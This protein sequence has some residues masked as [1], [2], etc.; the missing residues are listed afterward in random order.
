M[1]PLQF[2]FT[3]VLTVVGS[4]WFGTWLSNRTSKGDL[5]KAIEDLKARILKN[6]ATQEEREAKQSR[7]RIL[8]AADEIRNGM[9]HSQEFFDDVLEDIDNYKKYTKMHEDTFI[10]G[11]AQAAIELIEK[12]YRTCLEKN[13]FL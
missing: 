6:E 12:T 13:N 4:S 7:R 1:E 3:L 8:R 5:L 11:K 10:N 2:V 9:T